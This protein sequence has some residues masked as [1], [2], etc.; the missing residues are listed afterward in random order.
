MPSYRPGLSAPSRRSLEPPEVVM[1][2]GMGAITLVAIGAMHFLQLVP[3]FEATPLLGIAYVTF[4]GA[5]L[6]VAAL[7]V[8][9]EN[10][11]A[12]AAAGIVCVAA[13]GGYA[14]TRILST[15]FDNQD[16]GNWSCMLG[17]A[18]LFVEGL[19]AGLSAYALTAGN[20]SARLAPATSELP[21]RRAAH[22]VIADREAG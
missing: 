14:F 3:T 8:A 17:M 4:I 7:L 13:L 5:C 1:L 6:I 15:P 9:T 16:V 19:T 12:W 11:R 20:A 10:R 21:T 18:A 22:G 2:R